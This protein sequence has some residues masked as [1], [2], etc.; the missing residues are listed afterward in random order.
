MGFSDLSD[1]MRL[2]NTFLENE[3]LQNQIKILLDGQQLIFFFKKGK[4]LY[5]TGEDGRVTFAKMKN[6]DEEHDDDWRK[7]ASFVAVNLKRALEGIKVHN[8]FGGKDLD[9]IKVLDRD[10]MEKML[11]DVAKGKKVDTGKLEPE[12]TEDPN[13]AQGMQQLQGDED[14]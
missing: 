9:E 1:Y 2:W 13:Q 7:E 10:K 5:G 8:I 3:D 4:E 12:P 11:V 6:P 14:G